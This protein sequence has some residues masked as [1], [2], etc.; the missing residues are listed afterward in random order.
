MIDRALELINSR[1]LGFVKHLLHDELFPHSKDWQ[2]GDV[3]DRVHYLLSRLES[4]QEHV[5]FLQDEIE[6]KDMSK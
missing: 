4:L 6:Q 5:E 1:M 2:Q 3:I